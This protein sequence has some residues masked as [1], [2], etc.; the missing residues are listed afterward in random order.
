M[1][2]SIGKINEIFQNLN[3]LV[4]QQGETLTR[5]EDNLLDT[6]GN[7]GDT[8]DQLKQ[9]VKNEKPN[10]SERVSSPL[11]SDLSTTCLV[12]WFFFAFIMF[13]VDFQ[14]QTKSRVEDQILMPQP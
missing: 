2:Q 8:V 5:L 14:G 10:L 6:K 11:G 13:L 9:A 7:T 12:V 4:V 3:E 1:A